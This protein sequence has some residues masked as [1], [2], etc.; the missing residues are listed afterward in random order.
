MLETPQERVALLKKGVDIS[1]IEKLYLIY[2]NIKL[3]Q[4]PVLFDVS[5]RKLPTDLCRASQF[6]IRTV[7]VS[8]KKS[9]KL[10]VLGFVFLNLAMI[11]PITGLFSLLLV[12]LFI[13]PILVAI[14][15]IFELGWVI[16][17]EVEQ[18]SVL[19]KCSRIISI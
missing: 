5:V 15:I 2:N 11:F 4:Q 8:N 6:E 7:N 17:N 9:E 16:Y 12:F 13:P 3:V 10:L 1:T 19:G 18:I 14:S